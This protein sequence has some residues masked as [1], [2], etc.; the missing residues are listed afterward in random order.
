MGRSDRVRQRWMKK[1]KKNIADESMFLARLYPERK[2]LR[3]PTI[4]SFQ[5]VETLM[6][7]GRDKAGITPELH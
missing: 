7:W 1:L 6:D 2:Q 4:E 5:Q 3:S